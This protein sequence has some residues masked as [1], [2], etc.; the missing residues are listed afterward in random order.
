MPALEERAKQWFD[1][2]KSLWPN[3]RQDI[4]QFTIRVWRPKLQYYEDDAIRAAVYRH[5]QD[6]PDE[7][8]PTWKMVYELLG[9]SERFKGENEFEKHIR[10]WRRYMYRLGWEQKAQS[11]PSDQ[12]WEAY[13]RSVTIGHTHTLQA[14]KDVGAKRQTYE[15][16]AREDD[17]TA[18]EK[19][20]SDIRYNLVMRWLHYFEDIGEQPPA[21]LVA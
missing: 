10:T 19:L 12:V 7:N 21:Y 13:L 15:A 9:R 14:V 3:V 8:K 4:G 16:T 2:M 18:R 5:A 1:I 17:V 6:F 11:M 20:A